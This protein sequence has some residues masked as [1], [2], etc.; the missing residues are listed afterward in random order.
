MTDDE[1]KLHQLSKTIRVGRTLKMGSQNQDAPPQTAIFGPYPGKPLLSR[2]VMIPSQKLPRYGL[3]ENDRID[4]I[5][6]LG[7]CGCR[8]SNFLKQTSL[9]DA[10]ENTSVSAEMVSALVEA[11]CDPGAVNVIKLPTL[12]IMI[13]HQRNVDLDMILA[14]KLDKDGLSARDDEGRDALGYLAQYRRRTTVEMTDLLIEA[15]CRTD[16]KDQAFDRLVPLFDEQKARQSFAHALDEHARW[17][18]MKQSL[19]AESDVGAIP[20]VDWDR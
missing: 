2:L 13:R 14:L 15:G 8:T 20:G 3:T 4:A 11:G 12:L 1:Q 16:E 19:V 10:L 18:R 9:M 17:K 5:R 6:L 7:K